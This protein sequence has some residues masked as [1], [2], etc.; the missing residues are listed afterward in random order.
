MQNLTEEQ[1]QE[2]Y[3]TVRNMNNEAY[4]YSQGDR[5]EFRNGKIIIITKDNMMQDITEQVLPKI[6]H[7]GQGNPVE[8][9]G[10]IPEEY[11]DGIRK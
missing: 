9:E 10:L 4:S 1:V 2:I 3:R 6:A 7:I 8:E 5:I 11:Q